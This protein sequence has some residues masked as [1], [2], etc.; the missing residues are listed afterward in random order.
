MAENRMTI[1]PDQLNS[2]EQEIYWAAWQQGYEEGVTE[3]K[4]V[5]S[6]TLLALKRLGTKKA[7]DMFVDNWHS[8]KEKN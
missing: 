4:H 8:N 5:F 2:T 3:T 7:V 1:D 6:Q